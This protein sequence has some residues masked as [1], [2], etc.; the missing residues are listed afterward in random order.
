MDYVDMV[1]CHR[2]DPLTPTETVVRGMSDVVRSGSATCWPAGA[3]CGLTPAWLTPSDA[4]HCTRGL[5][6]AE[7]GEDMC[8]T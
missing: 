8:V 1:F 6:L 3:C 4:A 7:G 2:P 5:S